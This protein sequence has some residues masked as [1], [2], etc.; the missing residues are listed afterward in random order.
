M[1]EEKALT[2]RQKQTATIE[3]LV[4]DRASKLLQ[5]MPKGMDSGRFV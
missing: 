4:S 3:R 2:V 5:V 1:T